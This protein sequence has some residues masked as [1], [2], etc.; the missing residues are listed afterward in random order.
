[1]TPTTLLTPQ[2]SLFAMAG[3]I[4][5]A[6]LFITSGFAKLT[7]AAATK[8]YFAKT[9]CPRRRWPTSWR[10]RWSWAAASCSCWA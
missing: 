9:A 2:Q 4:G 5:L 10:W 1:M 7:A 3:R 8:A 6:L